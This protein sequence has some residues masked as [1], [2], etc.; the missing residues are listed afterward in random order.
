M[1]RGPAIVRGRRFND[2]RVVV[3][4]G[5]VRAVELRA[6][7]N[8][9]RTEY[10][11]PPGHV[12]APGF[13][14]IHVHGGAGVD[15]MQGPS[16]MHT[17]AAAL[18]RRGVTS[19]LPTAVSAPFDE[20]AGFAASADALS[21]NPTTGE[22]RVLGANLEGPA[23]DPGH[24]GAHDPANLV[25]AGAVLRAWR[26]QPERWRAVRIITIAPELPGATELIRYLARGGVVVSLGHSN[27]TFVEAM[28]AYDAGAR[29]TTHLF[30]AMTGIVH[31]APGLA[32][33]ALSH[34]SATAELIADSIHVDASLWPLVWRLLGNRL[35]LV[36]DAMAAAGVGDGRYT[37]GGLKSIVQDG[38]SALA[39][40]TLAGSTISVA[41]AVVNVCAAGMPL[42]GAVAA[43]TAAPA[44]L[45]GRRDVGRIARGASA[46]L[47]ILD[48][49]GRVTRVMSGGVWLNP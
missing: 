46:D 22:A 43:A 13:I 45:L 15:A 19:F 11:V 21:R 49:A 30:N 7:G 25:D 16:A 23:L 18:A 3:R 41:D 27:A 14:D 39:D 32:A 36:S 28:A 20:L 24:R 48:D 1:I 2:A 44:R 10:V 37:V 17:M 47:V 4:S 5:R 42:P 40:G 31:H 29:S 12:L 33:A 26:T 6:F 8:R 34:A 35:I 9:E 38:R